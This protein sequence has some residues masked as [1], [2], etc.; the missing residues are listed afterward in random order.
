MR[1]VRLERVRCSQRVRRDLLAPDP[2]PVVRASRVG[3]VSWLE[4]EPNGFEISMA[5]LASSLGLGSGVG[6]HAPIVRTLARLAD[7]GLANISDTYAVRMM[8]PPLSR[9]RS[10]GCPITSRPRTPRIARSRGCRDEFSDR[11]GRGSQP[12]R[13]PVRGE[14]CARPAPVHFLAG[15]DECVQTCVQTSVEVDTRRNGVQR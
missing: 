6:R 14:Q 3:S 4:A 5:A 13:S 1:H 2:G 10:C 15:T 8:F 7:F 11:T 9:A 12:D